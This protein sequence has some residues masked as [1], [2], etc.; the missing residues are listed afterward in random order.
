MKPSCAV[1][2]NVW[3]ASV[4]HKSPSE[5]AAPAVPGLVTA[6]AMMSATTVAATARRRGARWETRFMASPRSVSSRVRDGLLWIGARRR[7]EDLRHHAAV[8]GAA[9]VLEV[10]VLPVVEEVL[11]GNTRGHEDD[12]AALAGAN[13]CLLY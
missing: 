9:A 1:S 7:D 3:C 11:P 8:A 12:V 13:V 10:R 2:E 5:V 4:S 6:A